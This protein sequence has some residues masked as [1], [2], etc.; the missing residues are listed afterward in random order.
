M[1]MRF[2]NEDTGV[3]KPA[4]FCFTGKSPKP[5]SEMETMAVTANA[6]TTKTVT[7][8]TTILVIA[9]PASMSAK[10][11]KARHL[12]IDLIS[13]EQFFKMCA[14]APAAA[15]GDSVLN[16][17]EGHGGKNYA[18]E[19]VVKNPKPKPI[20]KKKYSLVRKIKL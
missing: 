10:A 1:P 9:D 14:G 3:I 8:K 13:P 17:V 12:E 5:R 2:L 20:D 16:V 6:S 11:K 19:Y 7:G 15:P 18:S 4:I